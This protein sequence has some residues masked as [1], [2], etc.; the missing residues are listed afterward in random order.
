MTQIEFYKEKLA[1]GTNISLDDLSKEFDLNIFY[2]IR[3][4]K[5]QMNLTPH[6]YLLNVRINK[7]NEYKLY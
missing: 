6:S 1:A 3:L 7:A 4:F 2:I 5:L